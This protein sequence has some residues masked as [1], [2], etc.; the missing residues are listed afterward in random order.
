CL[1]TRRKGWGPI[2]RSHH[3][4][5]VAEL[6]YAE[7]CGAND[8]GREVVAE[9]LEFLEDGDRQQPVMNVR[10]HCRY[11]LHE[12]K[13]GTELPHA[14]CESPERE[15]SLI[16]GIARSTLRHPLT[17]RATEHDVYRTEFVRYPLRIDR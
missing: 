15:I 1:N 11:V 4:E 5:P 3:H 2:E 13:V 12:E 16:M 6:R 14:I 7:P 17:H 9:R 10:R 8:L